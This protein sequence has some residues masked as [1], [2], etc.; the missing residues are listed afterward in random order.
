MIIALTLLLV[1][2]APTV[3]PPPSAA[4]RVA[5]TAAVPVPGPC[6][7]AQAESWAAA[8]D[9]ASVQQAAACYAWLAQSDQ[10]REKQ[11]ADAKRGREL[12]EKALRLKPE[13]GPAH[14][15]NA[16][17]AGLEAERQ[18]LHGR[19]LVPVI[20]REAQAAAD[21]NPDFD[22]G[23]PDRMLGELYLRA[24]GP[25][26]SIGD[27]E[28]AVAHYRRA[29]EVAPEN[30]EN[31]LGLAEALLADDQ[32]KA[33]CDQLQNYFRQ[34]PAPPAQGEDWKKAVELQKQVCEGI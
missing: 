25:P 14:Y 32:D 34:V 29:V 18:P 21:L 4:G 33:A 19:A 22:R 6:S 1:A 31:R 3:P 27:P 12:A 11:L 17:L 16:Y 24:P 10:E 13:S 28:K 9:A 30:T 23:G 8:D 20:E 15:L 7:R 5:P 2:C 26:I